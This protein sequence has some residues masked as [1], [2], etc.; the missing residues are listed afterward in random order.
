MDHKS[1]AQRV[2]KD[3]GG[4]SNI[5]AAAHC[6]TRLRLVL[7][8]QDKVDQ[9][10]ID[11]D[12]DLKGSF[13]NAG[14]FQIIVGPGDVNEV[15]KYLIA[16]G[17]PEAS[18]D[19]LKSIAAKQGNIVSRFIKT[20]ADIFVPLIPVL[21]GGG[22]LMAVNS[23]LTSK[24]IFGPQPFIEMYPE[25]EGGLRGHRE[26]AL[27]RSLRLPASAGRIL[28][29]QGLRRQ[30]LPGYDHGCCHGVPRP[31]ERLQCRKVAGRR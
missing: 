8:N 15:H 14:Q 13:L 24:G 18:K 29:H 9:A 4:A 22:M 30:P 12:E 28:R 19:D 20:I 27:R 1:V 5:V 23:V 31:D 21:V 7:K 25:W 2:L 11:N 6:A 3:V 17:A 10:A 16:A 26:P